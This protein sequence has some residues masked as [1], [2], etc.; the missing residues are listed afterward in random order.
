M[1]CLDTWAP[2]TGV[3]TASPVT[4]TQLKS[5]AAAK[6]HLKK[7][8]ILSLLVGKQAGE[9]PS[10]KLRAPAPLPCTGHE[11][12]RSLSQAGLPQHVPNA[13]DQSC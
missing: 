2:H 1:T 7:R 4:H 11:Q 3:Q 9:S 8:L 5:Q 13:Q 10:T 12:R 6:K